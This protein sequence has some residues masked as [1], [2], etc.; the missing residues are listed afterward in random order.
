MLQQVAHL[1]LGFKR[2]TH[3]A[4]KTQEEFLARPLAEVTGQLHAHDAWS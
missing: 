3:L 2:L 1:P 4:I